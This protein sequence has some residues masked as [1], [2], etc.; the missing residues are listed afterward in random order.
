MAINHEA[1]KLVF[2][3]GVA[4]VLL[5]DVFHFLPVCYTSQITLLDFAIQFWLLSKQVY[6]S[7][8][9]FGAETTFAQTEL[10]KFI[11]FL[12]WSECSQSWCKQ[13]WLLVKVEREVPAPCFLLI[14][15]WLFVPL[16][17]IVSAYLPVCT[18]PFACLFLH[19][20]FPYSYRLLWPGLCLILMFL[21]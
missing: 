1:R 21:S 10:L 7:F 2:R 6:G 12:F 16:L 13:A 19:A 18:S 5:T 8:G 14:C 17:F 4:T 20:H 9:D 11:G 15:V 3:N